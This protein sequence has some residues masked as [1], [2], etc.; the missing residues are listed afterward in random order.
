M[1]QDS[2]KI[3]A[4]NRRLDSIK[5]GDKIMKKTQFDSLLVH[6]LDGCQAAGRDGTHDMSREQLAAIWW[7]LLTVRMALNGDPLGIKCLQE[8]GNGNVDLKGI[9]DFI[10]RYS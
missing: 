2:D 4:E 10:Q 3:S 6:A 9:E 7:T 8:L 1:P 5:K